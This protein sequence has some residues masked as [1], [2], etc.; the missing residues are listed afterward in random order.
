MAVDR[1]ERLIT[2]LAPARMGPLDASSAPRVRG[3]HSFAPKDPRRVR[4]LP[5]NTACHR[6]ATD[7]A[8]VMTRQVDFCRVGHKSPPTIPVPSA[9]V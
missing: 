8:L 2:D 7:V 6:L 5:V 3:G 1:S 4:Q 9:V